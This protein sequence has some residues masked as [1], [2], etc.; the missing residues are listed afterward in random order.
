MMSIKPST[1]TVKFKALLVRG[2]D[3]RAGQYCNIVEM[4]LIFP[5]LRKIFLVN[6]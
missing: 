3:P 4:F 2:S 1:K 5:Q 6:A